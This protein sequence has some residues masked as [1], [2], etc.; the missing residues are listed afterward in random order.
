MTASRTSETIRQRGVAFAA[1][2]FLVQIFSLPAMISGPTG[3]A[4]VIAMLG[5][6]AATAVSYATVQD[7]TGMSTGLDVLA[8]LVGIVSAIAGGGSFG[9]VV[10]MFVGVAI[11]YFGNTHLARGIKS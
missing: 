4:T 9:G 2:G 5:A 1:V 8:L 7:R 6:A 10:G 11:V 3:L